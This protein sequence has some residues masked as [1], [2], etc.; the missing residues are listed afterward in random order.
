VEYVSRS[1]ILE[2]EI[3]KYDGD[4]GKPN[5][6]RL[7]ET[8]IATKVA[9]WLQYSPSQLRRRWFTEDL[10]SGLMRIR[11]GIQLPERLRRGL[12]HPQKR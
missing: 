6:V 4:L 8:T 7:D 12:P 10:F 11:H 9:N 2:F 1:L 5:L 3:P